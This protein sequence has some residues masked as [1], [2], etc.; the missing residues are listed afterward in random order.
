MKIAII[1]LR[2]LQI[3]VAIYIPEEVTEIISGGAKGIDLLAE[4]YAD[5]RN[6]AKRIIKPEYDKY[7]RAA[8]LKRNEEI[9]NI[10][11]MVIAIWDGKSHGTKYVIDYA[12]KMGKPVEVHIISCSKNTANTSF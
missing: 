5:I 10:S 7:G 9:V 6:I 12:Q 11:D 1:G 2:V 8:P 4:N 3:D